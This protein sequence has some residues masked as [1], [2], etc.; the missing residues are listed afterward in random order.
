MPA[1]RALED[2]KAFAEAV[3]LLQEANKLD[4]DSVA[5]ARRLS[6]LYIGALGKLTLK[7]AVLVAYFTSLLSLVGPWLWYRFLRELVRDRDL[8]L[9]GGVVLAALPSWSAIYSYFMQETLMLPLLGAALWAT[10]RARRKGDVAGF[11]VAV[12]AW[13]AAGLTRG[14]CL[15]LGAVA[16]IERSQHTKLIALRLTSGKPLDHSFEVDDHWQE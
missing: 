16:P 5:I 6:R 2:R 4:P 13:L 3:N 1:A 12:G 9:A 15:P 7:Y 8:A 11:V 14:I 10:W